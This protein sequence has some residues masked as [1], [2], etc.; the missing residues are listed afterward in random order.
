MASGM[1]TRF[2]GSKSKLLTKI[3]GK[4]I[5]KHL[6]DSLH[7]ADIRNI[8]MVVGHSSNLII[9]AL[10]GKNIA[11]IRNNNYERTEQIYSYSLAEPLLPKN[12][13][14]LLTDGDIIIPS[15][16]IRRILM[17]NGNVI[18]YDPK[19]KPTRLDMGLTVNAGYA[20]H[21]AYEKGDGT[22]NTITKM[23]GPFLEAFRKHATQLSSRMKTH[24]Q[25]LNELLPTFQIPALPVKDS[26]INI[27]YREDLEIAKKILNAQKNC[28]L[29]DITT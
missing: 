17:F 7:G 23:Q 19:K 16:T 24:S 22:W 8:I 13:P 25:I 3:N 2:G 15:K 14:L 11:F 5:I 26:W 18:P 21:L 10:K 9:K 4:P 27:N 20:H 28:P 29:P 1:N 6:V 12:S